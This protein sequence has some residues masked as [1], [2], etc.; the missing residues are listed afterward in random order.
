MTTPTLT[1]NSET[2]IDK[3]AVVK[4]ASSRNEIS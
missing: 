2:W 4:G 1:Y 3:K